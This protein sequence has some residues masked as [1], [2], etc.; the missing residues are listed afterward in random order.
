MALGLS[1]TKQK[2]WFYASN[3]DPYEKN[4]RN[5]LPARYQSRGLYESFLRTHASLEVAL[6]KVPIRRKRRA[7]RDKRIKRAP[8]YVPAPRIPLYYVKDAWMG[9]YI[10]LVSFY[11]VLMVTKSRISLA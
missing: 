10:D 1:L 5:K 9:S 8:V 7:K 11:L 3:A 4:V 6:M 2:Q